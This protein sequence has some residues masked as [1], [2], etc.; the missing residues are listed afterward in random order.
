[1]SDNTTIV[2]VVFLMAIFLTGLSRSCIEQS[3]QND[4]Y[5]LEKY[6]IEEGFYE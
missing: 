6:K 2:I 3:A 5:Y 4:A 1:M